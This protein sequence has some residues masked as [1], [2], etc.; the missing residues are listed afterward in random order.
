ML[1]IEGFTPLLFLLHSPV[2][3]GSKNGPERLPELITSGAQFC[4]LGDQFQ[5]VF[6]ALFM[7]SPTGLYS[8][9]VNPSIRR[10]TSKVT[11]QR[12]HTSSTLSISSTFGITPNNDIRAELLQVS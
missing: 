9:G 5:G 8:K 12:C 2:G 3:A 11:F 1:T 4:G 7:S 6:G 10:K